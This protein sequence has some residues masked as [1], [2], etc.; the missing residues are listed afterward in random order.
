MRPWWMIDSWIRLYV[1]SPLATTRQSVM[2][3]PLSAPFN[4][5]P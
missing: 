2:E 1:L 4:F 5:M 3:E